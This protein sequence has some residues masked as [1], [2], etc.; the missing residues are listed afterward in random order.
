[1]SKKTL[2]LLPFEKI[3]KN[4]GKNRVSRE[5]AEELRNIIEE[6]AMEVADQSAKLA[7]HAGRRTVTGEDIKFV[8]ERK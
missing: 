4:S 6:Y 8:G 3:A 7:L 2:A 1:M 5:A